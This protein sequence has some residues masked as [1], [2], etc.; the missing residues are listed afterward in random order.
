V[1]FTATDSKGL[2]DPA[3]STRT[4]TVSPVA[5]NRAPHGT[6]TSPTSNTSITAGQAVSFA[7]TAADPDG[8]AV[9]VRW[10]FGDGSTSTLLA[11]GSHT[12]A[13]AGTFTVT[14][15]ATDSK[16]LVD[17]APSTR[18]ITVN[19]AVSAPTL[20]AIKTAIFTPSCTGC[21]SAGGDAGMNLTAANAYSNLVNV[22][23]TTRSGLRVVPFNP[24]A[25]ALVIQLQS[26]HRSVSAA[27]QKMI[28]DWITAGALN[29]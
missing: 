7:G 6:I 11:P 4:I 25:S 20:T 27:N 19:P 13:S 2:V 3:P 29:N 23:A 18:T 15:T 21:H 16:G 14:F 22:P 28:S 8:D 5:V 10:A 26:G 12:Y 17:P 9:T 1:T 24:A